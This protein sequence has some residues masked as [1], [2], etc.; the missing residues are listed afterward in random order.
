MPKFRVD[1]TIQAEND[2]SDIVAF[3]AQ[4]NPVW[5]IE[6]A[7]ELQDTVTSR[8]AVFPTQY[9]QLNS[10]HV[11]TY[12]NYLVFFDIDE[13]AYQVTVLAICNSAQYERYANMFFE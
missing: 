11:M 8:L 1:I 13:I 10:H 6:F 5:A 2:M 9:R 12:G 7:R 3:I 4:D